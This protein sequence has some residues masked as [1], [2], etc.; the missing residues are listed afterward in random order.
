MMTI[1]D[2][3]NNELDK[4]NNSI[5]NISELDDATTP[6]TKRGFYGLE[7]MM[8]RRQHVP[9]KKF[10]DK[11]VQVGNGWIGS[12]DFAGQTSF[13]EE[14]D[15]DDVNLDEYLKTYTD[16]NEDVSEDIIREFN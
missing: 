6:S 15:N 7:D 2:N 14:K 12:H 13:N 1:K 5:G 8:V 10:V 9:I 16:D 3:N 11:S 4:D